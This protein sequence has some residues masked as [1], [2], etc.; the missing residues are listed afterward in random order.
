LLD[1]DALGDASMTAG[2]PFD[3]WDGPAPGSESWTHEELANGFGMP[4]LGLPLDAWP[5]LFLAWPARLPG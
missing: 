3:L 5:E 2:E 4:H 1:D